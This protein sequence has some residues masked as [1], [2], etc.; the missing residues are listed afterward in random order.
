M[1]FS[2]FALDVGFT[3]EFSLA[4]RN[5]SLGRGP[6]TKNGASWVGKAG[7]AVFLF[8]ELVS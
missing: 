7:E 1:S 2:Q 8:S 4:Q 5:T 6:R 3:N